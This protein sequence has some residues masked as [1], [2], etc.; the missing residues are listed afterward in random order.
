MT[1]PSTVS[2]S[3]ARSRFR[4]GFA[5]GPLG[6]GACACAVTVPASSALENQI[7]SLVQRSIVMTFSL[8]VFTLTFFTPIS[9]AEKP[10]QGG[11]HLVR[12]F[13]MDRELAGRQQRGTD[14]GQ[15]GKRF[16]LGLGF[17]RRIGAVDEQ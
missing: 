14:I 3:G 11:R 8:F 13:L 1:R 4:S 7:A 9:A 10:A 12:E 17:R 15:G 5:T 6:S 2:I 16:H